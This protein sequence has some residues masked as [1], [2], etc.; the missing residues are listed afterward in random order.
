MIVLGNRLAVDLCHGPGLGSEVRQLERRV[1]VS[2]RGIGL[3]VAIQA[4]SFN[5]YCSRPERE[6]RGDCS[7]AGVS[8]PDPLRPALAVIAGCDDGLH[9]RSSP[10]ALI[11][12][13]S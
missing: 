8:R 2:Q 7:P 9:G 3:T 6:G 12:R 4:L 1:A 13:R 10:L 11:T 5:R